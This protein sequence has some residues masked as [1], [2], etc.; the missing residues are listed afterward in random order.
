[1]N[2]FDLAGYATLDSDSD[3][4]AGSVGATEPRLTSTAREDLA[5][6]QGQQAYLNGVSSFSNPYFV[7][8]DEPGDEQPPLV[9]LWADGWGS[10]QALRYSLK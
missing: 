9:K 4:Q 3:G 5:F 1:M 10:K 8:E 2:G 7:P 6:S